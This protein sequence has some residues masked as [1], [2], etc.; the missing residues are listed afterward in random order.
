VNRG[1]YLEFVLEKGPNEDW[2]TYLFANEIPG[3]GPGDFL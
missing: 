1:A 3:R 2:E